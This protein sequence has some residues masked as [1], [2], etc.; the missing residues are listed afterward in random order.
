[1]APKGQPQSELT[2]KKLSDVLQDDKT[3]KLL[4]ERTGI[5]RERL[6]QWAKPFEKVKSGPAGPGRQIE[7]NSRDQEA[8]KPAANLPGLDRTQRMNSKN[9]R[10]R[11]SL[12]QDSI[13][14]LKQ[15]LRSEPP[16]EWRSKFEGY[17]SR[18]ARSKVIATRRP[19]QPKPASPP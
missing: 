8:A 14:G 12:P 4:E 1:M 10:E 11:G 17:K 2:L 15:D 13:R 9:I 3:A 18:L 5:S 16:P 7:V 6:E 19:A